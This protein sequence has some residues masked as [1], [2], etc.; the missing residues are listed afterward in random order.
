MFDGILTLNRTFWTNKIGN[1]ITMHWPIFWLCDISI[2]RFFILKLH[3]FFFLVFFAM[4]FFFCFSLKDDCV[5]VVTMLHTLFTILS[6]F[7][8]R[9]SI[10]RSR[11]LICSYNFFNANTYNFAWFGPKKWRKKSKLLKQCPLL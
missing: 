11:I 9:S 8:F 10:C 4:T 6:H 3:C 1:P 5:K 7:F 2:E